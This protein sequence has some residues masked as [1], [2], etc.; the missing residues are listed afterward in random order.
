MS[1]STNNKLYK[2][3][4]YIRDKIFTGALWTITIL[5]LIL[6]FGLLIYILSKG[7]PKITPHFLLG[8]PDEI[9]AGGGVGPF[10]FNS[11]YVLFL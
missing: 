1:G 10:L 2:N 5:A 4:N 7:L 8:L 9:E 3:G 6:I 11:F